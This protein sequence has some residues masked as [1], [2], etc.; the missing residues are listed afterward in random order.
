MV[1][2]VILKPELIS[3]IFCDDFKGWDGGRRWKLKREEL[4]IYTMTD[5]CCIAEVNITL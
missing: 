1:K 3:L 4:Y 2:N 5:S